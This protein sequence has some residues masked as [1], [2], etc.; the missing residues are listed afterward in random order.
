MTAQVV[1]HTGELAG[2]RRRKA[3]PGRTPRPDAVSP[4]RGVGPPLRS[5]TR[6]RPRSSQGAPSFTATRTVRFSHES[7][8]GQSYGLRACTF[9]N[10]SVSEPS[11]A[12]RAHMPR[13][14]VPATMLAAAGLWIQDGG[15]RSLPDCALTTGIRTAAAHHRTPHALN[16]HRPRAPSLHHRRRGNATIHPY[17]RVPARPENAPQNRHDWTFGPSGFP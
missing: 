13:R 7:L 9:R 6:R 3:R 15:F 11:H 12:A 14:A 4:C 16:A 10:G 17:I 2:E 8:H 5:R 1:A